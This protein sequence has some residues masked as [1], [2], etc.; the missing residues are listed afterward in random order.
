MQ[1]VKCACRKASSSRE[2]L[3]RLIVRKLA[4]LHSSLPHTCLV[5][6][7]E[8]HQVWG[9]QRRSG[10]V[11]WSQVI[12]PF[13]PE[14]SEDDRNAYIWS[15]ISNVSYFFSFFFNLPGHET[16]LDDPI[17]Q[18]KY[19]EIGLFHLTQELI[20]HLLI[21]VRTAQ[22]MQSWQGRGVWGT[23]EP[24]RETKQHVFYWSYW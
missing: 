3:M 23:K 14:G 21:G 9:E 20:Y 7:Q 2:I 8:K 1:M 18:S 15:S 19:R 5:P 13:E 24:G 17:T 6:W 16:E 10:K 12:E 11:E 22:E 4:G